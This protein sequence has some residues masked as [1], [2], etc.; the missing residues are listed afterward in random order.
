MEHAD[1]RLNGVVLD[2]R[3][4]GNVRDLTPDQC[5]TILFRDFDMMASQSLFFKLNGGIGDILIA[6]EAILT[7]KTF[8]KKHSD[9]KFE[10]I[11][12]LLP[13]HRKFF[14]RFLTATRVFDS[15]IDLP[16]IGYFK[17]KFSATI[18]DSSPHDVRVEYFSFGSMWDVLWAKWG[19]PGRF[20][21][22]ISPRYHK[23]VNS[24]AEREFEDQTGCCEFTQKKGYVFVVPETTTSNKLWPLESWRVILTA[25]L[26]DTPHDFVILT[27]DRSQKEYLNIDQRIRIYDYKLDTS[28][29]FLRLLSLVHG[30]RAVLAVDT[31]PAHVAGHITKPCVVLW[32]PS[33]PVYYGH[34][35]NINVRL[36]ACPP[37]W[38]RQ[39]MFLCQD[40]VCLRT[41][42]PEELARYSRHI[43]GL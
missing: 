32:G 28:S 34:R 18:L 19:L 21:A 1:G 35:N 14:A 25:L 30:A 9:Q 40:N 29:D 3:Y 10:F 27:A 17:T 37:C 2:K 31:G 4:Q 15:V 43:L 6:F 7:L 16:Q 11:G 39:R 8:L 36:S 41:I 38:P 33:N 5:R 23:L 20:E 13:T 22:N 12:A 24:A 42:R 26:N